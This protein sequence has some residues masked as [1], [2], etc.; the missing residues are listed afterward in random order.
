M[1]SEAAERDVVVR[2]T[3]DVEAGGVFEGA[4]VPKI[5][6]AASRSTI[7][8]FPNDDSGTR[9]TFTPPRSSRLGYLTD[10]SS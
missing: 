1:S 9:R 5:V 8:L 4:L 3:P 2:L 10:G 7:E 6:P